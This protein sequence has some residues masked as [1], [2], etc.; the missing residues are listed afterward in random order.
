TGTSATAGGDCPLGGA[1]S[2]SVTQTLLA[3][4]GSSVTLA[5]SKDSSNCGGFN[6]AQKLVLSPNVAKTAFFG[7]DDYQITTLNSAA[8]D[9]LSVRPV[10]V[11]AGQLGSATFT[12]F[13]FDTFGFG[14]TTKASYLL[15][16]SA[17]ADN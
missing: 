3:N 1:A 7:K 16:F 4:S 5:L 10:P 6:Q 12:A 11:P 15:R 13:P 17:D 14:T 8:G 9:T 2:D